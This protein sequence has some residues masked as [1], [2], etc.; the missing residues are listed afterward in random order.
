MSLPGFD[1]LLAS[2]VKRNMYR[3]LKDGLA[4][5]L[6]TYKLGIDLV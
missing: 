5:E 6:L 1:V 2:L 3:S 4:A